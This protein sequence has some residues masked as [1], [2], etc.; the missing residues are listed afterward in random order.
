MPASESVA[1]R[2]CAERGARSAA[3]VRAGRSSSARDRP[4]SV[5]RCRR[6]PSATPLRAHRLPLPCLRCPSA[7]RSQRSRMTAAAALSMSARRTRRRRVPAARRSLQ[8]A[9]RLPATSSARPRAQ[10]AGRSAARA[11]R[12][13]AVGR[14]AASAP[15]A[16]VVIIGAAHHQHGRV[17]SARSGGRCAVQ[18]GPSRHCATVASGA[19]LRGQA[20]RR[21]DA[22]APQA[23]VEGEDDR[24]ARPS[25][26]AWPATRLTRELS[27]PSICQAACQR[28]SYGSSNTM[29]SFIGTRQ[30]GVVEHLAL[31]LAGS[32]PA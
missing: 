10:P 13:N 18:S 21:G 32:Q 28:S 31:E 29:R 7:C 17:C 25:A 12:A 20:C 14:S 8:C 2:R 23:E 26:Q 24:A 22:D 1:A 15:G 16:A 27:T 5:I 4:S 19:A 30:P 11:A 3:R 6:L 9:R